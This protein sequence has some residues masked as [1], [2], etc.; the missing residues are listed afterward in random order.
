MAERN[1]ETLLGNK[2]LNKSETLDFHPLKT[3]EVVC[4]FF[5]ASW[6]PPCQTFLSILV[7]FYNEIN[8]E[9]KILEIICKFFKKDIPRDKS[10]EEFEEHVEKMPWISIPY[11]DHR[12]R[13]LV[14]VIYIF[15]NIFKGS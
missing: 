2:F 3:Y 9:S 6:C 11:G 1:L 7:D 10:K 5:S 12:N 15:L 4:L 14:E 8:L 13:K